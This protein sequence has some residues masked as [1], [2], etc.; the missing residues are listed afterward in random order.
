M[1]MKKVILFLLVCTLL[2]VGSYDAAQYPAGYISEE[3]ALVTSFEST[4]AEVM[5]STISCWAK[6]NDEFTG[7]DQLKELMDGIVKPLKLENATVVKNE[8]YDDGLN[9]LVVYGTKSNKAYNIAIES[10]KQDKAGETYI[11]FDV[12]IDKDYKQ[13]KAERQKIIELLHM[14][15]ADI[16]FSS[17]IVGTYEGRLKKKDA[18]RK[19]ELALQSINAKPVEGIEDDGMKSVSAF[20]TNVGEYVMSE[21]ERVNVQLA[22]R[23]SSYDDKTYIWIGTPLIP[24]GY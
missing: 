9:K 23:Y 3:E 18:E 7:E 6:L 24:M 15:E 14:N 20:S 16:N 19:S 11:I 21:R 17:C 2:S 13:L 10:L 12:F 22:I 4:R 1:R 5:E 8:G